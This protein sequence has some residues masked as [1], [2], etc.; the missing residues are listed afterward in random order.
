MENTKK[1][2]SSGM[3]FPMAIMLLLILM[4]VISYLIA[5]FI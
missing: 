5:T 1:Y 2:K 3:S 4:G